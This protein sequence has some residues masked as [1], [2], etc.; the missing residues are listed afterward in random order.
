EPLLRRLATERPNDTGIHLQL[1]RVLEAEGKKD[2]AVV[3]LQMA[4]KLAP[5]DVEAQREIADLYASAGKNDLA[6]AAGR[7]PTEGR[8][9]AP[10]TGEGTAAAEEVPGGSRAV[11]DGSAAEARLARCLRG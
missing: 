6:E 4:L 9:V 3:E 11:S 2:D 8:R 5:A 1:G 7:G 10:R